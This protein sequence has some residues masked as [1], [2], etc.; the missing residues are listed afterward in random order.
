MNHPLTASYPV[1]IP[2]IGL[3]PQLHDLVAAVVDDEQAAVTVI[4]NGTQEDHDRVLA[5]LGP[6]LRS[7]I[8]FAHWPLTIYEQWNWA[9]D[10]AVHIVEHE[11]PVAVILNDDLELAP[12]S[13]GAAVARLRADTAVGIVGWDTTA[14]PADGWVST[15]EVTGSWR[16]NGIPGF[17]FACAADLGVRCDTRFTWWGGDDDLVW[18]VRK[19]GGR[20]EVLMGLGVVH[21]HSVSANARPEV[22]A[23]SEQD[24]QLLLEKWGSTW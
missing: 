3:A 7:R 9:L 22:Y 15:R 8:G 21:H 2:S 6:D 17:A 10:Q 14:P 4:C 19:A 20:A 24:R 5:R 13:T 12:G 1:L 11:R 16:L 23:R 18:A